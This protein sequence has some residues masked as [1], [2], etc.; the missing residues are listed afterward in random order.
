MINDHDFTIPLENIA[1]QINST[2]VIYCQTQIAYVGEDEN[3]I[4]L[5]G[6]FFTAFLGIFDVEHDR[7][8]FADS[9][10]ALPG[11]SLTCVSESCTPNIVKPIP[12]HFQSYRVI[13]SISIVIIAFIICVAIIWFKCRSKAE[14]RQEARNIVDRANQGKKGYS[15][16]DEREEDDEVSDEDEGI[17]Y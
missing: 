12:T 11:S 9:A 5:G 14:R 3:A 7:I 8:G 4:V 10:R 2:D 17:S 16:R 6:A 13:L 15:L 1:V